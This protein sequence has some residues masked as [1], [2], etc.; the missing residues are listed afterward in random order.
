MRAYLCVCETE[1]EG[2]SFRVHKREDECT[3]AV[4]PSLVLIMEIIPLRKN[5]TSVV[6][7]TL[8]DI[9][10]SLTWCVEAEGTSHAQSKSFRKLREAE[11]R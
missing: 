3:T 1:R 9:H 2:E 5:M 10:A 4:L 8:A 6:K 7:D 11:G